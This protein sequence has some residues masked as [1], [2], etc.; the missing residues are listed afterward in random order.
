[1]IENVPNRRNKILSPAEIAMGYGAEA[2]ISTHTLSS[3]SAFDTSR[4]IRSPSSNTLWARAGAMV[5]A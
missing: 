5:V 1:V 3:G 2:G 4:A